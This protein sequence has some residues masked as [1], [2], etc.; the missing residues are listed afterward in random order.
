MVL[1]SVFEPARLAAPPL[2]SRTSLKIGG[3][4][5]LFFE[6][7]SRDEAAEVIRALR[8]TGVPIR[9]L[10]GG[11]NVL[12][13]DG[14]LDGAVMSSR[15]LTTTRR[16][17]DRVVV[18]AGISFPRLVRNAADWHIP[19][20]SGC[21]GIPGQVGGVIAMNAGGR[22]GCVSEALLAV[23]GV[24]A[25]GNPFDASVD[26]SAF[27]Y[28]TSPFDG[29]F[30]TGATFRREPGFHEEEAR[31]R[32]LDAMAWKRVT[33]PLGVAS[34]GCMFKNPAPSLSAGRLIEA[35]GMKGEREG[36]AQVSDLHANFIVNR[37][38]ATAED[39][40]RL[41]RRIQERVEE[42]SSIVLELEVRTW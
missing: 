22:F 37:G 20:I 14:T 18:G 38:D 35:A 25:E 15:R 2:S 16:E 24:D 11:Y 9:F 1:P 34:A 3:R 30:I 19:T 32:F 4:P 12:V 5:E 29:C 10:G 40:W 39:V 27:G 8:N 26:P 6:P 23:E 7:E 17:R 21:P 31:T 33:Q 13:R 42:T 28:R 41:I 36:G